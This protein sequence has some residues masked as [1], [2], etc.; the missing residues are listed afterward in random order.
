MVLQYV[1][2]ILLMGPQANVLYNGTILNAEQYFSQ[3]ELSN[4]NEYSDSDYLL[5]VVGMKRFT[6]SQISRADDIQ[7][8]RMMSTYR[9]SEE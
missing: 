1:Q 4:Q 6:Y 5:D 8:E 9:N 3:F 7:M 2:N